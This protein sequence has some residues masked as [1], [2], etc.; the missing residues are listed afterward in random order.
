MI[1]V[2]LG[3]IGFVLRHD[4]V[5]GAECRPLDVVSRGNA[6]WACRSTTTEIPSITSPVWMRLLSG[7]DVEEDLS[8]FQQQLDELAMLLAAHSQAT[9]VHGATPEA[10]ASRILMRDADGR[11]RVAPPAVAEDI[12]LL[13]NLLDLAGEMTPL[14]R[15]IN[16]ASPLSG[17]GS[18]GEDLTLAISAASAATT[19]ADG[20][21]GSA[22]YAKD[23]D[24]TSRNKAATPAGVAA[25]ITTHKTQTAGVH[26]FP[27]GALPEGKILVVKNG[28]LAWDHR[29]PLCEFF[30]WRHPDIKEGFE[31]AQGG[32]IANA[33]TKYPEAWAYLQTTS[34]AKLKKTQAEWTA[35]TN[36]TWATLADGTTVGWNG[37]GGAPY[38]VQDLSAGSLRMPD[39]RGM[40]AEAAGYDSLGVGRGEG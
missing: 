32:L 15:L 21:A 37:I 11:A 16:T 20:S 34:G 18:L 2:N 1:N 40:Y 9:N 36:A 3:R 6:L 7:I 26:G 35:M 10:E 13:G 17:G 27:S 28:G 22:V 25:Q 24:A 19:T 31:A 30:Y 33:A 39:L 12:A 23:S 29:Y 5:D 14:N 4:Y 8:A 38:F